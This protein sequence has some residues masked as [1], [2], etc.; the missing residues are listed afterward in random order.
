MCLHGRALIIITFHVE[1]G[2]V[3]FQDRAISPTTIVLKTAASFCGSTCPLGVDMFC[4]V[5][6]FFGPGRRRPLA[7]QEPGP[8]AR[9]LSHEHQVK[10]ARQII[11]GMLSY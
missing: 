8:P 7:G 3:E 11:H 4:A 2:R 1:A 9:T 10:I 5:L 6:L